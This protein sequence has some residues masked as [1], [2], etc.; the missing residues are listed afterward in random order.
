MTDVIQKSTTV[1]ASGK[2][3]TILRINAKNFAVQ[4]LFLQRATPFETSTAQRLGEAM[5]KSQLTPVVPASMRLAIPETLEI[6]HVGEVTVFAER[7][8]RAVATAA[9]AAAP[10]HLLR[11]A[12]ADLPHDA[13]SMNVNYFLFSTE[14]LAAPWDAYGDPI[15]LVAHAGIIETPPQLNRTCLVKDENGYRFDRFAFADCKIELPDGKSVRTHPFGRPDAEGGDPLAFSL[16]HGSVGGSSPVEKDCFD[17]A[18]LG[19]YALAGKR[20]GG[21]PIPRAG[22]VIRFADATHAQDM[23]NAGP[24][25]YRLAGQPIEAV[26]TGPQIVREGQGIRRASK[27]FQAESMVAHEGLPDICAPSPFGWPADWDE[28]RAARLAAGLMSDGSLFFCA[29]EGT[30]SLLVDPDQAKGATLHDLSQLMIQLG[31]KEALHLDGGGSV[32]VFG[33]AG[34]ALITPTDIY[35]GLI[36]RPAQYDRPLPLALTLSV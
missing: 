28:T 32:Q 27:V 17:V 18:Y 16:F 14:E 4:P 8:K 5:L 3:A 23:A 31:A 21:M 10:L 20:G 19:R 11:L 34:G 6:D 13:L 25:I 9:I 7:A 2:P 30:S 36:D 29:V 15:G 12:S 24:L 1:L 35:H 22:C 26:Q 33:T